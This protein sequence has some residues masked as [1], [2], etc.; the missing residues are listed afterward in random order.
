[1]ITE[2]LALIP[3]LIIIFFLLV[4][5]YKASNVMIGT[6]L[7]T[8]IGVVVYWKQNIITA[9]S[10]SLKGVLQSFEV[11]LII[12]SVLL[13]YTMMKKTGKLQTIRKFL[14]NFS[15]D[16]YVM[17]VLIGWF[18]V[19]FFEGIAGF[20]TPAAV[21]APLLVFLGF[22]P[23]IA[24]ILC[25]IG[26]SVAVAFG[27]FGV[28]VTM[29]IGQT[30]VGAD[31]GTISLQIGIINAIVAFFMPL[32]MMIVYT[33]LKKK[34]LSD[35]KP[36]IKFG[37]FSGGAF[38]VPY[39]LTAYFLGPE[40]PSIVASLVGGIIV[41][42]FVKYGIFVKRNKNKK[43]MNIREVFY[44]FLPYIALII[45]LALTRIKA[46]GLGGILKEIGF[47]VN[48]TEGISSSTFSLYT[49]GA[50]IICIFIMVVIF[51]KIDWKKTKEIGIDSFSKSK[52][53]LLT[54]I[55]TL[56]FVQLLIFS[57]INSGGFASIPVILAQMLSYFKGGYLLAVP[58]IGAFGSFIAGSATVSNI[59]FASVHANT[60][61]IANIPQ[62]IVLSL[63]AIGAGAGNMIAIHNVVAAMALVHLK[64]GER[65]IIRTNVK[66]VFFYCLIAGL[67]GFLFI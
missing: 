66:I 31:F 9:L 50:I 1:M 16:K 64:K 3:F 34:P 59:L 2:I 51:E 54:L 20:G 33:L 6:Y 18:L 10:A 13:L 26:D 27:A 56:A 15:K 28:P 47:S 4:K 61:S 65:K 58:F 39:F 37:L 40:L 60:A 45:I 48:F 32:V 12:I 7:V 8:L 17:I 35:V 46:L 19:S 21:A 43:E 24:V 67:I 38:A 44:A 57:G 22:S 52:G 23:I 29:G 62:S 14:E 63:Q 53:A 25:L 42:L 55:F 49:P 11:Y 41:I 36:Y 30:V 5:G